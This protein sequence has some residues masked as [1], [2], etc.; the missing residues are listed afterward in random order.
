MQTV[1]NGQGKTIQTSRSRATRAGARFLGAAAALVLAG[2]AWAQSARDVE[3]YHGIVTGDKIKM[4]SGS[5]DQFYP[6][7]ELDRSTILLVD[8]ETDN[9]LRVAYPAGLSVLVP[10]EHG[11]YDD[12]AKQV[13]LT[14]NSPLRAIN[15][16][17]G[18]AGSWAR[19]LT[20]ALAAGAKLSVQQ[21]IKGDQDRV[22]AYRVPAPAAARGWVES[23]QVRRAT[24]EEVAEFRRK[25]GTVAD[26]RPPAGAPA[27][28]SASTSASSPAPTTTPTHTSTP[29]H[30]PAGTPAAAGTPTPVTAGTPSG[31]PATQPADTA[32]PVSL[33]DPMITQGTQPATGN[34]APAEVINQTGAN[35]NLTPG[36]TIPPTEGVKPPASDNPSAS[37]ESPAAAGAPTAANTTGAESASSPLNVEQLE[38][39]FQ[40]VTRQPIEEAEYDALIGE[41]ER[42]I[43]EASTNPNSRRYQQLK[44]R[45]DILQLRQQARDTKLKLAATTSLADAK[46]EE[47]QRTVD[48]VGKT[49][50]YSVVGTLQESTVYNGVELPLM[51]RV[52]SVGTQTPRT[53]GYIKPE[54]G[55]DFKSK[56]GQVVG[57]I[58]DSAVDRALKLNVITPVRVDVL[59]ASNSSTASP[60]PAPATPPA[61]PPAS[62][63]ATPAS[64]TP[65]TSVPAASSTP[66][67]VSSTPTA[68]ATPPGT[69]ENSS[70]GTSSPAP[71]APEK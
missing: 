22:L 55:I 36:A 41:Y 67:P 54:A 7:A 61:T 4:R 59:Q 45:L 49:R 68:P 28:A 37:G 12:A 66:A 60:T 58:G 62:P 11:T 31:G 35:P 63:R 38:R 1:L 50:V 19:V 18:Q 23:R 25:G 3:P 32:R 16:V 21:V 52:Q 26:V 57:V 47:A 34:T 2:L 10:V 20:N 33:A 42:A 65:S 17:S 30:T 40:S 64:S 70:S 29:A 5:T 6:I 13:T 51:Y 27:P 53:L 14:E 8:G 9:W 39:K 56:V 43:D 24:A 15:M 46:G 44:R 48:E 71:G 69:L